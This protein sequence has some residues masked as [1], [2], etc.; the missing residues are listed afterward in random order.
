MTT[1]LSIPWPPTVNTYYRYVHTRSGTR[2]L[3]SREG[4]AYRGAVRS[5]AIN[6]RADKRLAGRLHVVIKAYPKDRRRRDLDNLLKAAL[7]ALQHAGVFVD[8]GQ[9]DL[10]EVRRMTPGLRGHA[11]TLS[12][13]VTEI[14]AAR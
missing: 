12:V 14:G 11:G 13:Y 3:I 4:R 6:A 8:D 5:A 7:D 1:T 9:I 2:V 10:I